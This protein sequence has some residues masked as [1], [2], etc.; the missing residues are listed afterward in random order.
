MA[1][2]FMRRALELAAKGEG[3]VNP[4]PLVGAVIVK[5]NRIIGEG[6]HEYYGGNHAEINAI[7]NSKESLE[8]ATIY[9]TLEPCHHYGKTP[10]CV[11]EIIKRKFSKVVIGQVDPNPLVA[12]KSV[13]KLKT[14]GIEVRVGVL[15][16]E[17][18]KL[19]EVFNKYILINKPYVVLKAAMSLDGKIATASG[20]SMWITGEIS[21]EN[22]HKLRNKYSAIM[23]GVNTIIRDNPS[24]T[25]RVPNGR[26]PIRI[27]VDSKLRIPLDSRVL[28]ISNR[29][30]CLIATTEK[31]S[32]DKIKQLKDR[33]VEV[34][35]LQD[36][37]ERV[38]I[39]K[40]IE[41]LGRLK[42]DGVLLEGGGTLNFSFLEA[43]LV[44]KV[45]FY[46]APKI[47]GGDKAK[48]PVEGV[49]IGALNEAFNIKNIST[50]FLGED[51]LIEGYLRG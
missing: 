41:D 31:A 30:R 18:K 12:G 24:L 22:V 25:C 46:I 34:L 29:S 27:I 39:R 44:D 33:G 45:E 5:D 6:Y 15:E 26:N 3:K 35:V 20:E 48:T 32:K 16:E 17:C 1:E 21:R 36:K 51:L 38:D 42:I 50:K 49:G 7:K 8:G 19:N 23:V 28:D 4:N 13:E 10:P 43:G 14:H 11:D 2:G 47:I 40:L 9:V 37:D